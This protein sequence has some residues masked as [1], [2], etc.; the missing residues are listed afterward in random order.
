M[1]NMMGADLADLVRLQKTF[2]DVS[3]QITE[4]QNSVKGVL[5]GTQW[6]GTAAEQFRT[7][8]SSEYSP[9]FTRCAADLT[10]KAQYVGKRREAIDIA[11]RAS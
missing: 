1:A 7:M 5:G 2:S 6:T 3:R 10:E 11:T 9:A 8:W 4:I